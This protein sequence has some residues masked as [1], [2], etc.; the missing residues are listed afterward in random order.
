MKV[1]IGYTIFN[2]EALIERIVDALASLHDVQ[3]IFLFDGCTD[4]SVAEFKKYRHRL[5][6][7]QA[8]V[9]DGYDLFE[10]L[11]NNFILRTFQTDCCILFQGDM[12]MKSDSLF[13]MAARIVEEMPDAGLIGFKDGYEMS[14]IDRY[15]N[16]ISSPFSHAKKRQATLGVDEYCVRTFVNR[17]PIAFSRRTVEK[18]GYLDE[19]YDPLFWDDNDYCM[20]CRAAGLRNVVAYGEIETLLQWGATRKGSKL[21]CHAVNAANRWR[22]AEKWNMPCS[23]IRRWQTLCGLAAI[24]KVRIERRLYGLAG[25]S[26][27][28]L[29]F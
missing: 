3:M 24:R 1:T 23:E 22:F 9:N 8:F 29:S 6:K 28:A 19:A 13:A 5:G 10:P 12:V 18:V 20:K 11:A 27:K 14:E 26:S 25:R 2:Q 15:E 17:G 21:P 7:H 4:G 16:M